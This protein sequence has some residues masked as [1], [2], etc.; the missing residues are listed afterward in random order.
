MQQKGLWTNIW[1]KII[2]EKRKFT[3]KFDNNHANP[4]TFSEILST[5]VE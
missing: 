4:R 5:F 1:E 2:E 3:S